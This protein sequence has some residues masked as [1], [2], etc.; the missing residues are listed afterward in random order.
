[1]YG[2]VF[3][4][5]KFIFWTWHIYLITFIVGRTIS[6]AFVINPQSSMSTPSY[7]WM[8]GLIQVRPFHGFLNSLHAVGGCKGWKNI[9]YHGD[10]SRGEFGF[11]SAFSFLFSCHAKPNTKNYFVIYWK[12]HVKLNR[13]VKLILP[14][15]GLENNFQQSSLKLITRCLGSIYHWYCWLDLRKNS[16]GALLINNVWILLFPIIGVNFFQLSTYSNRKQNKQNNAK[17][18]FQCWFS[19][20]EL[21]WT[22]TEKF[23]N[24]LS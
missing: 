1:M 17:V 14:E 12:S 2:I 4:L 19:F 3:P 24:F 9:G 6:G 20:V 7:R 13:A 21:L 10:C 18:S 8:R 23:I 5:T 16:W 15:I 11:V 22:L